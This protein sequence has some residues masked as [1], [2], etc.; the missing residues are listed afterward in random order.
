MKWLRPEA[1]WPRSR[2]SSS[3]LRAQHRDG[4]ESRPARKRSHHL[5]LRLLLLLSRQEIAQSSPIFSLSLAR[6]MNLLR[7]RGS[8]KSDFWARSSVLRVEEKD[9]SSSI[10]E[11]RRATGGQV[12][13]QTRWL[14]G[15]LVGRQAQLLTASWF[16]S[17][18]LRVAAE[19]VSLEK[20]ISPAAA[21]AAAR[22]PVSRARSRYLRQRQRQPQ[23]ASWRAVQPRSLEAQKPRSS[24]ETPLGCRRLSQATSRAPSA[25][26]SSSS[27]SPL[28]GE[29]RLLRRRRCRRRRR[30]RMQTP[31]A[32]HFFLLSRA[33]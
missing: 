18:P 27:S 2:S 23:R 25:C 11:P 33:G 13:R 31:E 24:G 30:S 8:E 29:F 15:R 12:G 19:A 20:A 9:K 26:A 1:R 14:A 10:F 21:A 7:K 32:L 6:L 22:R 28:R 17:Q 16:M 4:R 5:L 3:S